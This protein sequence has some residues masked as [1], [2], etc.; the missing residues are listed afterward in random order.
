MKDIKQLQE[1]NG[2]SIKHAFI[3]IVVLFSAYFYAIFI[4]ETQNP[5]EIVFE[6]RVSDSKCLK[7]LQGKFLQTSWPK[8][9]KS[10]NEKTRELDLLHE[11][12]KKIVKRTCS[13]A[14]DLYKATQNN[15]SYEDLIRER[16]TW[17]RKSVSGSTKTRSLKIR[18]WE[19]RSRPQSN[20]PKRIYFSKLAWTQTP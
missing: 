8:V 7:F 6:V 17:L 9:T 10:Q 15:T 5:K 1:H 4:R 18:N 16:L 19:F 3:L 20:E 14:T 2:I 13:V 12:R 11:Y